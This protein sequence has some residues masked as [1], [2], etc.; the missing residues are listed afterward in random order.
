MKTVENGRIICVFMFAVAV[1]AW[2]A[3]VGEPLVLSTPTHNQIYAHL[4]TNPGGWICCLSQYFL[5]NIR[6]NILTKI[7]KCIFIF[8]SQHVT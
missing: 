7:N 6:I 5:G 8:S 2:M 4:T 3:P 1:L